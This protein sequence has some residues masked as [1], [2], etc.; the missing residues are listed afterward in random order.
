M[1]A[2]I[3]SDGE[4]PIRGTALAEAVA[5]EAAHSGVRREGG[6]CTGRSRRAGAAA[7]AGAARELGRLRADRGNDVGSRIARRELRK[8]LRESAEGARVEAAVGRLLG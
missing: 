5:L 6:A 7:A 2:V 1:T 4:R 3:A 8:W